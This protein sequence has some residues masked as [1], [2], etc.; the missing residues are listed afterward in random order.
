MTIDYEIL[1]QSVIQQF[2]LYSASPHGPKHW[3]QVEQNGLHITGTN[4]ADPTVVKLFAVFHDSCRQSDGHDPLHGQRGAELALSMHGNLFTIEEVQ[5]ELL[6]LACELHHQ[7]AMTE[8]PTIGACFDADR[9]D[10]IRVG[11]VPDPEMM[12]TQEGKLLAGQ[13]NQLRE[14]R[15]GPPARES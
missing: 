4:D 2:Q 10:L 8:D 5:L 14:Q 6:I 1:W 12:C 7:G 15:G 9:L 13:I 3:K 11:I